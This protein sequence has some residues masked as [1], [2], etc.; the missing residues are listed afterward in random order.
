MLYR[1]VYYNLKITY[2]TNLSNIILIIIKNELFCPTR[3]L[4]LS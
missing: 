4:K 1:N 2:I 3:G